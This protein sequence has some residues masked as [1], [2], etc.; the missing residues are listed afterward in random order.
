MNRCAIGLERDYHMM[1]IA[2]LVEQGRVAA[3]AGSADALW[4][5]DLDHGHL[6]RQTKRAWQPDRDDLGQ[7]LAQ[8]QADVLLFGALEPA[9]ITQLQRQGIMLFGGVCGQA[10]T[11][12]SAFADGTLAF[13]P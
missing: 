10:E 5:Y 1:T 4:F 11:S 9:Q 3:Q 13:V 6:V 8:A 2:L 12:A 7:Q